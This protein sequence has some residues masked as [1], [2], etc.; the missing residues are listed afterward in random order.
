[1]SRNTITVIDC[2]GQQALLTVNSTMLRSATKMQ[3]RTL[4]FTISINGHITVD[5]EKLES[6]DRDFYWFAKIM[7]NHG[8]ALP[9]AFID[10]LNAAPVKGMEKTWPSYVVSDLEKHLL[11]SGFVQAPFMKN[12]HEVGSWQLIA[13]LK[14]QAG[15]GFYRCIY[16]ANTH[17]YLPL[18]LTDFSE[19]SDSFIAASDEQL[20]QIVKTAY[21]ELAFRLGFKANADFN[22]QLVELVGFQ[23]PVDA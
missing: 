20:N 3:A 4:E 11:M 15:L 8:I 14:A 2:H 16:T 17:V 1:M 19:K 9:V 7:A 18:K 10:A 22:Q 6:N 12:G 21:A 23:P 5:S 13:T